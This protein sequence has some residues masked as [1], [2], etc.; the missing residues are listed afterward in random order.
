M[1]LVKRL[2]LM[3]ALCVVSPLPVSAGDPALVTAE[4]FVATLGGQS[5][6][7]EEMEGLGKDR[8]MVF[9]QKAVTIALN[10]KYNSVELADERSRL[11]LTETGRALSAP[12]LSAITVE[13]GGHADSTGDAAYNQTLSQRRA[14]QIRDYLVE[15]Y[16]IDPQRL[17]C[18][19]YGESM[20]VASNASE[21]GRARNRRVVITRL[22]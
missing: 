16:R 1:K 14:E 7:R 10:F 22:H 18:R 15:Y 4:Q 6:V 2:V 21:A 3:S 20:P 5:A 12:A 9:K 8:V 13:I 17:V 11:Q 19:G